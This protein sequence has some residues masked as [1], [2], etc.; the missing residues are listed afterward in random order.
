ML[1]QFSSAIAFFVTEVPLASI[2]FS[3]FSTVI[4]ITVGDPKDCDIQVYYQV[5]GYVQFNVRAS[6]AR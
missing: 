1:L 2:F 5:K 6:V 3:V 4:E